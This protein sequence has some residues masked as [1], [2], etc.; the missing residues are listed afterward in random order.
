MMVDAPIEPPPMSRRRAIAYAVGG[1]IFLAGLL[2]VPAGSAEW[3]N[4]WIFLLV[5]L[6]ATV[7]SIVVM[8]RVNP[9]I[10][11]ARSRLQ[12]G[13]KLWDK[14]LLTLMLPAALAI[15]PL[16]ALDAGRFRW[17]PL[18]TSAI[19]VGYALLLAGYALGAWAQAVNRFFE[20]GVR[21][22]SERH[23][24]V[25]DTGPYAVIR[26]PGY[27]SGMWVFAGAALSLG[28]LWALIPAAFASLILVIRT[29]LEERLLR[30]ELP[31]YL[32]Y[33]SRIRWRLVPGLW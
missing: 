4:G 16:A 22:Q 6:T 14:R 8:R 10:F 33:A 1:P 31:G 7:V 19:V 28:S 2:F 23:H 5:F 29:V 12:P 18:P 32:D 13:T 21:I 11:R 9:V 20:P 15:V 24:R 27:V 3:T 26:H 30:A 17:S 25:I